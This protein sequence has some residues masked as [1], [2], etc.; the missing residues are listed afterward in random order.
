MRPCLDT[1]I[2]YCNLKSIYSE[3]K[4]AEENKALQDKYGRDFL[5]KNTS[6]NVKQS[7]K[8]RTVRYNNRA[9]DWIEKLL[10]AA[11]L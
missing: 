9:Q 8:E 10:M 6:Q 5:Y 2:E 7:L 11:D 4:S 1:C 3:V